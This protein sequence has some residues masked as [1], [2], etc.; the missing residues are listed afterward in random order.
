MILRSVTKHI[1]EQNWFAVWVDFVIVVVG[2]FVGIEVA[3][4][5]E[6]QNERADEK[7]IIERLI[8]EFEVNLEVL[9]SDKA[10]HVEVVKATNTLLSMIGP[11]PELPKNDKEIAAVLL[12]CLTNPVFVPRLGT[13]NSLIASGDLKLIGD[14]ELQ[15]TLTEWP[16]KA[17]EIG[18]WQI[19]E[20]HH[21][22]ELILGLTFDYLA[23]PTLDKHLTGTGTDSRFVSDYKGLLSSIKLE[24][25]LNNRR[26]N[27]NASIERIENLETE[28]KL[29]IEKLTLRLN[30][31]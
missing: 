3:N 10:E 20:R 24:G 11:E 26:W 21:G 9:A 2:V 6:V 31:I 30:T 4:W 12:A 25:L 29:L 7:V 22:E 18:E 1:N 17:E 23:W 27:N 13:T 28:T 15:A 19:I 8:D 5:N 14:G 16:A